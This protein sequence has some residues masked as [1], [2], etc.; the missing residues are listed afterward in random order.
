MPH[1]V[2]SLQGY[3]QS[4]QISNA[5]TEWQAHA[6]CSGRPFRPYCAVNGSV[7]CRKPRP[8]AKALKVSWGGKDARHAHVW[9]A[10]PCSTRSPNGVTEKRKRALTPSATYAVGP[11]PPPIG[12]EELRQSRHSVTMPIVAQAT[13]S[14][15]EG[16]A[17][18]QPLF[19]INPAA[20]TTFIH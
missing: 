15:V 16:H 18:C 3:D 8:F 6:P 5:F 20:P 11:F 10:F 19:K 7:A 17:P 2:I 12:E 9:R 4:S 13:L 1:F 14:V